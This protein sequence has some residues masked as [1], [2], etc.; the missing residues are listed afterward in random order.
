MTTLQE[1]QDTTASTAI[2]AALEAARSCY[3]EIREA[4][5]DLN[6]MEKQGV[7]A[8]GHVEEQRRQRADAARESVE[9]RLTG[10][11]R[12]VEAAEASVEGKL[13]KLTAVEPARLAAAHGAISMFLGDLRE[14]P[15]QLLTAYEQ[16]FDVPADR[17]AIEELAQRA[18]RVLPDTQKRGLFKARW[19]EMQKR[20]EDR[21]PFDQRAPR[22]ALNE[23]ARAFGYLASVEQA[24][25]AA[26]GALVNPRQRGKLTAYSFASVYE[27]ELIGEAAIESEIPMESAVG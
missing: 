3:A 10:A 22:A 15:A 6:A 19:E 20:L 2:E 5:D 4:R 13:E 23:L 18:L 1:I 17:R 9:A 12:K 8:E 26:I 14:N 25:T 11:R 27:R 21:L 24:T 7:Y 16:S